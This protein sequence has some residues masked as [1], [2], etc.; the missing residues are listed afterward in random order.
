MPT[1]SATD[2]IETRVRPSDRAIAKAASTISVNEDLA[3]R[4]RDRPGDTEA[5]AAA[6]DDVIAI[7][8]VAITHALY[9]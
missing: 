7:L 8:A 5:A 4:P 9:G 1:R 2:R 3:G 6:T